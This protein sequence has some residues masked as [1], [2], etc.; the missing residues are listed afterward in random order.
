MIEEEELGPID[1]KSTNL[2]SQQLSKA[3]ADALLDQNA[4][5]EV[6]PDRVRSVRVVIAI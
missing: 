3:E 6:R 5:W 4:D 1:I 2:G